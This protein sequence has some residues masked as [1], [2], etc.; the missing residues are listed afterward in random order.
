MES[1]FDT[2]DTQVD[3]KEKIER[4]ENNNKNRGK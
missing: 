4:T 1:H 2:N 3:Q